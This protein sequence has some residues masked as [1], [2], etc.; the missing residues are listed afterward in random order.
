ME[1]QEFQKE[2]KH[3]VAFRN[4]LRYNIQKGRRRCENENKIP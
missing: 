3:K 2:T 1:N 4:F